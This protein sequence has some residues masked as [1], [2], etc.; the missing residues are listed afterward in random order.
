MDISSGSGYPASALSNFAPHP[1]IFDGVPCA[2]LEGP[3]QAFKFKEPHIQVEVCKL[4]GRE[5]KRRGSKKDWRSTQTL[6]WQG[7]AYQRSSQ[8]YQDLLDRLYHACYEQNEG[9]RKALAAS[10]TAVLHSHGTPTRL[11]PRRPALIRRC[12]RLPWQPVVCR[13]TTSDRRESTCLSSFNT[14]PAPL[15]LGRIRG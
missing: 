5:A 6:W 12:R 11:S 8:A 14:S 15:H 1:F 7:V 9:F 10:G 4:V 13:D 2:G 3:L